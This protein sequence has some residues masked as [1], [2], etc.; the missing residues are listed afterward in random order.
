M[1]SMPSQFLSQLPSDTLHPCILY[2]EKTP[3]Y[4]NNGVSYSSPAPLNLWVLC[5]INLVRMPLENK[6]FPAP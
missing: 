6:H 1:G 2:N 5:S 3:G 4:P